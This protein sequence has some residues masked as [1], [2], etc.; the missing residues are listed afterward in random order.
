MKKMI[1]T[2]NAIL[3]NDQGMI[4]LVRRAKNQ[5]EG[6][7]WSLPGGTVE[8]METSL[9]ALERELVEEIGCSLVSSSFFQTR[10]MEDEK[11]VVTANYFVGRLSGTVKIDLV[12]LSEYAWYAPADLPSVLAYG[13]HKVI[14]EYLQSGIR[15]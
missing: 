6:G 8:R 7:M 4:L 1:Q 9:Q 10:V 15:D 2:A 12:E 11:K 5:D 3:L 14:Q 13:Q